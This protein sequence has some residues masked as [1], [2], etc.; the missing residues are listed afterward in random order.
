MSR[1]LRD[2]GGGDDDVGAKH[3]PSPWQR[4]WAHRWTEPSSEATGTEQPTKQTRDFVRGYSARARGKC[5]KEAFWDGSQGRLVRCSPVLAG[6]ACI[7][8]FLFI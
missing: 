5:N 7:D 3:S 6:K 1:L 2:D 4:F 8:L